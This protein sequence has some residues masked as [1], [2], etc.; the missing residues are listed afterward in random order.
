[1][2]TYDRNSAN[3]PKFSG[4]YNR[5]NIGEAAKD[6]TCAMKAPLTSARTFFE[7]RDVIS[8][9]VAF[10]IGVTQGVMRYNFVKQKI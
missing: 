3:K 6:I 10:I 4:V 5:V 2:L 8:F 9:D 1:M 7:N